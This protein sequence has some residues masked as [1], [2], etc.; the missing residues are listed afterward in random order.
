MKNTIIVIFLLAAGTLFAQGKEVAVTEKNISKKWVF[1]K[2]INAGKTADEI[3]EMN[4]MM[5]SVVFI[6]KDDNT[7]VLDFMEERAGTWKLD[8]IKKIITTKDSRG[9]SNWTIHS[10]TQN[11]IILS[12]VPGHQIAFKAG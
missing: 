8:K 5:E 4:E 11:S 3:K 9:T 1:D 10:L 2:V 7:F 6:F 12:R